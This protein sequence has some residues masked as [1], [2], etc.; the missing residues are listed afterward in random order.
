MKTL[1]I[2]LDFIKTHYHLFSL[3]LTIQLIFT[4]FIGFELYSSL[5]VLVILLYSILIIV[6]PLYSFYLIVIVTN[7]I[8]GKYLE[9]FIL[10]RLFG[11][12]WYVMDL[13]LVSV[14]LSI[15][16]RVFSGDISLKI[17]PISRWLIIFL[18]ICLM[19]VYVGINNGNQTQSVLF[20]LRVFMYYLIFFPTM[21][22]L[23]D[24]SKL[25]KI[26][27]FILVIGII[28]CFSDILLSLFILPKSFDDVSLSF[29]PFARLTGYSEVVY[30]LTLVTVLS[31]FFFQKQIEKKI[32]SI[33]VLFLSSI[34][35]FL[36]YTRGSWMAVLFTAIILLFFLIRSKKILVNWKIFGFITGILSILLF[37]SSLLEIISFNVFFQRLF[38]VTYEKIDIS[39][40]GRLVEYVTAIEAFLSSPIFG[41]GFGF[42]FSY[43][44][45]GIGYMSTIYCHNSYLY[46]LSKMGLVGFIP[47]LMILLYSMQVGIKLLKSKL[48]IEEI[49]IAFSFVIM[50]L[51]I[52]IKSFTTWHLNTVTFSLF[53]GLLF[54]ICAIYYN[55]LK[56]V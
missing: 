31:Y 32:I 27:Y 54:G 2:Y 17:N 40:L 46:I 11:F 6:E 50:L 1:E 10:F 51:F 36:S 20:D 39:N 43:F 7:L 49:S 34:A 15:F 19:S 4:L 35:L 3:L 41:V 42:L 22:V 24:F 28:K 18:A 55:K 33:F 30:P 53:I 56:A 23:N 5:V 48:D 52:V 44:S 25:K 16:I 13:V 37:L 14:Y 45:P 47:F 21:F 8:E 9:V 29:L 38:S 26:F 12:N